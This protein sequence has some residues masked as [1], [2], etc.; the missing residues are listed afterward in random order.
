MGQVRVE[1]DRRSSV[2]ISARSTMGKVAID[3]DGMKKD[4]SEVT[5]GSG[6][7]SLDVECTMGNVKVSVD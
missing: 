5:L 3:A 2:R 4:R 7:G 6:E 1:L